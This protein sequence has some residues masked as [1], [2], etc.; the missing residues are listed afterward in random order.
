MAW[1]HGDSFDWFSSIADAALNHWDTAVSHGSTAS[2]RFSGSRAVTNGLANPT[3]IGLGKSSGSNDATHHVVVAF[4]HTS[5]LSGTTNGFWITLYDSATAQCTIVFRSDGTILLTS[6]A[7]SGSTLATYSSAFA[8]GVW[9]AFEFEITINNTTGVFKV[10]KDGAAS[11]SHS[12]TSLNTRGGT[13]NDYANKIAIGSGSNS[14]SQTLDDFLWF[15]TGGAAPNTWIGDVRATQLMPVSDSAVDFLPAPNPTTISHAS[16]AGTV[17]AVNGTAR[18]RSFTATATGTIGTVIITA[19]AGATA[20]V[21]AAIYD[22]SAGGGSAGAS[23]GTSNVLVNPVLGVNTLT[24]S[25]PVAVVDGVV[26]WFAVDQDATVVWQQSSASAGSSSTISYVS[27]PSATPTLVPTQAG[28]VFTVNITPTVNAA[29][30]D[31]LLHD[32]ATSYVYSSNIGDS[33]LYAITPLA[34]TPAV[35]IAI[36][37][38]SFMAKSDAGARVGAIQL[39]SGTITNSTTL[40][41][42]TSFQQLNRV[43][44]VDPN[45]SSA[46]DEAGVN[47]ILVGPSLVS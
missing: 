17:S 3:T 13:A 16:N 20:N 26:Y 39:N 4:V 33:D 7:S 31:E 24:W 9:A 42:S 43:D 23:L 32:D 2:G 22:S 47:A 10:R 29:Q 38:R 46:W 36:Q 28:V 12:T 30:V 27:F 34:Y 45:T 5:A 18:F 25:S 14:V 44:A 1:L 6:G 21:K 19:N 15:N 11:D 37:T 41:L 35:I 8:Q 40:A